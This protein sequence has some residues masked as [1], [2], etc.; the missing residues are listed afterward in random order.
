M[1]IIETRAV[2]NIVQNN[3]KYV[4]WAKREDLWIILRVYSLQDSMLKKFVFENL[5]LQWILRELALQGSGIKNLPFW[6][7]SQN[8]TKIIS[9]AWGYFFTLKIFGSNIQPQDRIAQINV[10][11]EKMYTLPPHRIGVNRVCRTRY[12]WLSLSQAS[13]SFLK[14]LVFDRILSNWNL[15]VNL[16]NLK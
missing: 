12:E 13:T 8:S 4:L 7:K 15:Y 1:N 5:I 3:G 16:F 6:P 10:S 9:R 14:L 2:S 11:W